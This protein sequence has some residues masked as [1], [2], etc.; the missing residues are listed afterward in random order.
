[1]TNDDVAPAGKSDEAS[2]E[3]TVVSKPKRTRKAKEVKLEATEVKEEGKGVVKE[4]QTTD[5]DCDVVIEIEEMKD[6][7]K[8]TPKRKRKAVAKEAKPKRSKAIKGEVVGKDDVAIS[9]GKRSPPKKT[10]TAQE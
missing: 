10:I 6:E 5:G 9:E 4:E 3:S 8:E 7:I 2:G 1:M